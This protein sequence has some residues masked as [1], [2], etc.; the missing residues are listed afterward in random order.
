MCH[1][2]QQ[3]SW[4]NSVFQVQKKKISEDKGNFRIVTAFNLF[5]N[6]FFNVFIVDQLLEM[7]EKEEEQKRKKEADD[8]LYGLLVKATNNEKRGLL[9]ANKLLMKVRK[10]TLE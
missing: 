4:E 7:I 9:P 6:R 8:A 1:G 3:E 2:F 5:W 10:T